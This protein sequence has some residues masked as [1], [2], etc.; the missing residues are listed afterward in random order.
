VDEHHVGRQV[1]FAEQLG[2]LAE[3][4]GDVVAAP[5]LDGVARGGA[6]EERLVDEGSGE[7]RL[8]VFALTHGHHVVDLDVLQLGGARHERVD[9]VERLAAGVPEHHAV[10]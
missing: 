8:A 9:Q 5:V 6:D 10:A 7:L 4:H 2:D 3:E 1:A